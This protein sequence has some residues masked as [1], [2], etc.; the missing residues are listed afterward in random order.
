MGIV[1]SYAQVSRDCPEPQVVIPEIVWDVTPLEVKTNLSVREIMIK[2]DK[3]INFAEN[4]FKTTLG[5]YTGEST[6]SVTPSLMKTTL[7]NSRGNVKV[8]YNLEAVKI[9]IAYTPKIYIASEAMQFYCTKARVYEHELKHYNIDVI[10]YNRLPKFMKDFGYKNL[11]KLN[12][13]SDESQVMPVISK[14]S[15]DISEYIKLHTRPHH[16]VMDTDENYKREMDLCSDKENR[17]L[18]QLIRNG[19][20]AAGVVRYNVF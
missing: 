6:V 5:Y 2:N 12:Y 13:I 8:C 18:I 11:M 20:N 17:S 10:A 4:S 3:H 15:E 1:N 16:E 7:R 14:T 19:Q 9:K